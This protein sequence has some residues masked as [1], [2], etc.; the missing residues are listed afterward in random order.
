MAL[1]SSVATLDKNTTAYTVTNEISGG[2]YSAGGIT[3][4]SATANLDG[5]VAYLDFAD[6]VWSTASF[7]AR[8]AL[9]Y[10][11]GAAN[12]AVCTL[13]FGAD[14]TCS[15]GSFTVTIPAPAAGTALVRIS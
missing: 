4:T 5:D 11:S 9:I 10:N 15:N 2:G 12:K 1:Y 13:D 7:T 3:L 14:Y 8:G 6:P